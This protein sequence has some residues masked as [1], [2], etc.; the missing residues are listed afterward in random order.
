MPC[1]NGVD[2]PYN[3]RIYNE[4]AMH[5]D[6]TSRS[7]RFWYTLMAN[8]TGLEGDYHTGRGQAV[9]CVQCGE[10]ELECPQSIPIGQWMPV[11]HR[12]L[13]DGESIVRELPAV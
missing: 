4:T 11:V 13:G 2:I 10:C 9:Q 7:S 1:P 6:D 5:E 8:D 3:F 12:V